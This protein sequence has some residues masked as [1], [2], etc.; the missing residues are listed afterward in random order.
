[1]TRSHSPLFTLL[2]ALSFLLS[3]CA[4]PAPVAPTATAGITTPLPSATADIRHAAEI[5]FALVGTVTG[6]NVW[7]LFDSKGYS[8]N[9]YA[10]RSA[11]WP[12]LY[13]LTIPAGKFEPQAAS[14][15]PSAVQQE[16][17]YYTAT[18]ALRADLKWTDGSPFTADDVAFSVNTALSF[19]LGFDW[20]AFYDP[21]YLDH[22]EAVDAH[23]VKFYFKKAP[24]VA[25]WQY[26]A[27][28]GPIVQKAYWSPKISASVALLPTAPEVAQIESISTQ[29]ADLQKSINS[30]I[31]AGSTATGAQARQLQSQLQTQQGN[32]DGLNNS[33][34]KAH[35]L[36]DGAM[37][38]ARQSLYA[39]DA[40]NEPTLGTWIPA[41]ASNNTWV[42]SANPAH[43]FASPNFDRAVYLTY[44][45]EASAV[46]AL[47]AGQVNALLEPDGTSSRLAN[48]IPSTS[49]MAN[50]NSSAEFL[51]INPSAPEL[52]EPALR[53]AFFCSVDRTSGSHSVGAGFPLVSYVPGNGFWSNPNA[54]TS[55]GQGYDP[56][57]SF[58][59]SRAVAVLKAAGYTWAK[60][61]T[62]SEAGV[63]LTGPAGEAV[64]QAVVLSATG[65]QDAI[66]GMQ[67]L[68]APVAAEPV[69]SADIRYALL[70][71]HNY[72][73]ALVG[74]RL[75]AYPG[76]LCDWFGDGNPFGYN[77]PQVTADCA[78]LSTT[79]DLGKAQQLVFDIQS[80]LSQDPPFIPLFSGITYDVTR[81]IV[82]PF[83][84]VLN[85]LSG[86][87]GAPELA[88]PAP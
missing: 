61:P 60:E 54:G 24:N 53:I 19:Q 67:H 49:V 73:M 39:L 38:A 59:P 57:R 9:N 41:G 66:L 69:S 43:P 27:L 86:V 34:S 2:A 50:Q 76:Y 64:P 12:R 46:A 83:T 48:A 82:Y 14:A 72:D 20:R 85:G 29:V 55:C 70:S 71:D 4:R 62:A 52:A 28:Q 79:T 31:I 65:Q 45:D 13:H 35:A 30:L 26:G 5:K 51:V 33:L 32:L 37:D 68:G 40:T 81:G 8:Y 7:A 80:A 22:A 17:A 25:V 36:V 11:Y 21:S 56:T 63:G 84:N 1:M 10:V 74:W 15:M 23:T 3:S 16:G 88:I 44:P 87:Y 75:S 58:D 77:I 18:V 6:A 47:K 42:N 78:A